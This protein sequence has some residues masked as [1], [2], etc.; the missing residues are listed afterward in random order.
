M[1][2]CPVAIADDDREYDMLMGLGGMCFL[3]LDLFRRTGNSGPWGL[4]CDIFTTPAVVAACVDNDFQDF[5]NPA[6]YDT[7]PG[8]ARAWHKQYSRLEHMVTST[9]CDL[10]RAWNS[11]LFLEA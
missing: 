9:S 1:S 4:F 5:L 7:V 11:R 8:K 6:C 3:E 2:Q 10:L